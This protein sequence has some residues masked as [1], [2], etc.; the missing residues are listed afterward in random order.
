MQ[1]ARLAATGIIPISDWRDHALRAHVSWLH[2]PLKGADNPFKGRF[3]DAII[4]DGAPTLSI[5][6]TDHG[7]CY[8]ARRQVG[9]DEYY[10]RVT[11]WLAPTYSLIPSKDFPRGEA[12]LGFRLTTHILRCSSTPIIPT[13][14]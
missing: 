14:P 10:W 3:N 1:L 11:Q 8:G 5:K 7:F 2:A 13:A 6:E 12:G 9:S 4:T